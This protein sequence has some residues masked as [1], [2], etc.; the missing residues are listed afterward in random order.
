[1]GAGSRTACASSRP[2]WAISLIRISWTHRRR[3]AEPMDHLSRRTALASLPAG[4]LGAA[5]VSEAT[6]AQAA[7]GLPA[8]PSGREEARLAFL[9]DTHADPENDESLR[10]E[11]HTSELQS[12]FDLV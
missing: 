2:N 9:A 7:P 8:A 3:R 5:A 10:S 12:R 11:E 1:C 4:L 6:A